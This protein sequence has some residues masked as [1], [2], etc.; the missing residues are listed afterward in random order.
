MV[1]HRPIETT[2]VT[3]NWNFISRVRGRPEP[4]CKG[5]ALRANFATAEVPLFSA[6]ESG[7]PKATISELFWLLSCSACHRLTSPWVKPAACSAAGKELGSGH[8]MSGSTKP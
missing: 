3:G 4:L 2:R 1:L 5:S 8:A 6:Q 7:V